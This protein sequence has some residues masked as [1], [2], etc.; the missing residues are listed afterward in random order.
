[1]EESNTPSDKLKDAKKKACGGECIA[2]TICKDVFM[3]ECAVEVMSEKMNRSGKPGTSD[4]AP[5]GKY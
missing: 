3:G 4:Y 5:K 2:P 1:M